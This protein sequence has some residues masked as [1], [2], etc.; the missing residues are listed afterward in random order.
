MLLLISPTWRQCAGSLHCVDEMEDEALQ[1]LQCT[2]GLRQ[3]F[4]DYWSLSGWQQLADQT[5]PWWAQMQSNLL[6]TSHRTS[7]SK[8]TIL[9][10]ALQ[11]HDVYNNVKHLSTQYMDLN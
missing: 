10:Y 2:P 1:A 9:E 11:Q 3:Q 5:P 7:A 8:N 4:C 6:G